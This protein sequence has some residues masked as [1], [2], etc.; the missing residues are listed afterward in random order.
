MCLAETDKFGELGPIVE[1]LLERQGPQG[2]WPGGAMMRYPRQHVAEPWNVIDSG[3]CVRDQ[4]EVFTTA[5]AV[6]A[7]AEFLAHGR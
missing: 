5:T 1:R 2:G 6:A 3:A 7:L 4:N